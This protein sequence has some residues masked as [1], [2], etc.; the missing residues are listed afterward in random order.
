[1]PAI[2]KCSC[3]GKSITRAEWNRLP[4]ARGGLRA[5]ELEWRNCT[6]CGST[7]AIAIAELE[8]R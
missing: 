8:A 5:M 1:M 2:K 3:C 7:L 4:P 6:S